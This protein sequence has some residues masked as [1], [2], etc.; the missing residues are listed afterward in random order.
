MQVFVGEQ[1]SDFNELRKALALESQPPLLLFPNSDSLALEARVAA[2]QAPLHLIF[3]D[4]TWRKAHKIW[5]LNT[6][7]QAFP[8]YHFENAPS[9]AYTL[10]KTR[11]AGRLSTL[12]AVAYGLHL[13]TQ[14]D[15]T[16]LY[17]IQ[18]S[19]V[20]RKRQLMP[21]HIQGRYEL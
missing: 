3:I 21:A 20:E 13:A 4:A 6:W 9:G 11:H 18:A 15:V 8:C 16:P 1:E 19:W 14:V 7:L 2:S 17:D 12:E 10:R 5:R